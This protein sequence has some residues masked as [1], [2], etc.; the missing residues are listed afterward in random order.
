MPKPKKTATE[1]TFK[2]FEAKRKEIRCRKFMAL[3]TDERHKVIQSVI[4]DFLFILN[5]RDRLK[6]YD[7]IQRET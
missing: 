1:V 7:P 5:G 6:R 3:N 2:E 4:K